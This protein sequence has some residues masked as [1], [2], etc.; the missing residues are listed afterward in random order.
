MIVRVFSFDFDGCIYNRKYQKLKN[1]ISSNELLFNAIKKEI[2]RSDV[3]AAVTFIGSNRQSASL[4]ISN[5]VSN[6]TGSCFEDIEVIN[7]HIGTQ[8]DKLLLADIYSNLPDGSAF[9]AVRDPGFFTTHSEC[10]FDRT[11]VLLL[12]AQ[13][14]KMA[15]KYPDDQIVFDFYDDKADIL[16]TIQELF[17]KNPSLIPDNLTFRSHQYAGE[18]IIDLTPI[19]G[20][21]KADKNYRKTVKNWAEQALMKGKNPT[22]D[23]IDVA[24]VL[25]N[26]LQPQKTPY[27]YANTNKQYKEPDIKTALIKTKSMHQNDDVFSIY[28]EHLPSVLVLHLLYIG[29]NIGLANNQIE[30]NLGDKKTVTFI[31]TVNNLD[32]L[33]PHTVS[34]TIINKYPENELR[35]LGQLITSKSDYTFYKKNVSSKNIIDA[36][37]K[38]F[39][40]NNPSAYAFFENPYLK[41]QTIQCTKT[42]IQEINKV[43]R[44]S[45]EPKRDEDCACV[46]F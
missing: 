23:P 37:G 26:E 6:R 10:W 3:I 41:E 46:I 1:V 9:D 31:L 45:S 11:K 30:F 7:K 13:M 22:N 33:L 24:F 28:Q 20:T 2:K 43:K 35:H 39:S 32:N 4:N 18:D 27:K 15:L 25:F 8:L 19:L 38:E 12:Y 36:N 29:L 14:H 34:L 5:S 40:D 21:G 16:K 17:S 42:I 44:D